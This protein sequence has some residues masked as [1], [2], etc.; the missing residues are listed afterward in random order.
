MRA[1]SQRRRR[2][3]VAQPCALTLPPARSPLVD[4][5]SLGFGLTP[6]AAMYVATCARGDAV[7]RPALATLS[8]P[9]R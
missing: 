3:L 2:A 6:T 4:W 7:R 1:R 8:N 5:E 9:A